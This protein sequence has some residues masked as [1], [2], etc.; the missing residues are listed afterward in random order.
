MPK[1]YGLLPH[2]LVE[3][4]DNERIMPGISNIYKVGEDCPLLNDYDA[5]NISAPERRS[6]ENW[7]QITLL[8]E[9]SIK[10]SS[11]HGHH[12]IK[13]ILKPASE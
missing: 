6:I 3:I 1:P 7:Q 5:D 10:S 2:K 13:D 4:I 8:Y 9:P 11:Y 12:L